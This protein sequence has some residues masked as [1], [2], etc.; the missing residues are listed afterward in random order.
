MTA[1]SSEPS[2]EG[3]RCS[4]VVKYFPSMHGVGGGSLT[5]QLLQGA[6]GTH[7]LSHY[8]YINIHG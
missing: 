3:L 2:Q 1:L 4:S 6:E 7:I 8:H 5:E